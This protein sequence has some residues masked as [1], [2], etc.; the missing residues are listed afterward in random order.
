VSE[1][2]YSQTGEKAMPIHD[3]DERD[4]L[5]L[6]TEYNDWCNDKGLSD[7]QRYD[8]AFH[9]AAGTAAMCMCRLIC[10]GNDIPIDLM[11]DFQESISEK[12]NKAVEDT[13]AQYKDWKLRN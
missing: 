11:A 7:R 5:S 3:M 6:I 2:F 13:F 1:V 10:N 9:C 4:S 8:F 12:L